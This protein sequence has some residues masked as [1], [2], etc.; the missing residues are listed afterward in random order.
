MTIAAN[1]NIDRIRERAE[2]VAQRVAA[3]QGGVPLPQEAPPEE[4]T[5]GQNFRRSFK[6]S[7]NDIR[8]AFNE[9]TG[10][11]EEAKKVRRDF[12]LRNPTSDSFATTLGGTL[13]SLT[14]IAGALAL[15][16]LTG[17][18]SLPVA[19][20]AA[21]GVFAMQAATAAG[22]ALHELNTFEEETGEK[23][24]PL[25]KTAVAAGNAAIVYVASRIGFEK[26]RGIGIRSAESLGQAVVARGQGQITRRQL[27]TT[28]AK[29]VPGFAAAG[30]TV[31]ALEEAAEEIGSNALDAAFGTGRRTLFQNVR[32]AALAGA[33]GGSLLG[34]LATG[35]QIPGAV[36]QARFESTRQRAAQA[37]E[38]AGQAGESLLTFLRGETDPRRFQGADVTV[39]EPEL[40]PAPDPRF[41]QSR[42][43]RLFDSLA[44]QPRFAQEPGVP[45]LGEEAPPPAERFGPQDIGAER[46]LERGL[47]RALANE[48]MRELARTGRP[49]TS[50]P[51]LEPQTPRQ[52][53][54]ATETPQTPATAPQQPTR[55][56]DLFTGDVKADADTAE[57]LSAILRNP[58]LPD[59]TV[60]DPETLS[61]IGNTLDQLLEQRPDL[62]R[63]LVSRAGNVVE[64]REAEVELAAQRT[65]LDENIVRRGL[66]DP[67]SDAALE[68]A[69]AEALASIERGP[70]ATREQ[71]TPPSTAIRGKRA[72]REQ[73]LPPKLPR[74]ISLAQVNRELDAEMPPLDQGINPI[75]TA[76]SILQAN[77]GR[78]AQGNVNVPDVLTVAPDDLD[79]FT[80]VERANISKAGLAVSEDGAAEVRAVVGSALMDRVI[81]FAKRGF[82]MSNVRGEVSPAL[83]NE[84]V[85]QV[86]DHP[87]RFSPRTRLNA[88]IFRQMQ[89]VTRSITG[90]VTLIDPRTLPIGT[91]IEVLGHE[92]EVVADPETDGRTTML[93][94]D[95]D[96]PLFLNDVTAVPINRIDLPGPGGE[97][98][99]G[100]PS[101][102]LTGNQGDLFTPP[103]QAPIAAETQRRLDAGFPGRT[104]PQA[105]GQ[106]FLGSGF[107]A[108][109]QY[110]ERFGRFIK[111]TQARA[112]PQAQARIDSVA[113]QGI[114]AENVS[115]TTDTKQHVITDQATRSAIKG[116]ARVAARSIATTVRG[117]FQILAE[118]SARLLNSYAELS[119]RAGAKE[120]SQTLRRLARRAKEIQ[121]RMAESLDNVQRLG[122]PKGPLANIRAQR[123]GGWL[124]SDP[125]GPQ[126]TQGGIDFAETAWRLASEGVIP[127]GDIPADQKPAIDAIREFNKVSGVE[128]KKAKPGFE[129]AGKAPRVHTPGWWRTLRH[130]DSPMFDRV[131]KATAH[132]NPNFRHASEN[133]AIR[134]RFPDAPIDAE[135]SVR[136]FFLEKSLEMDTDPRGR[137]TSQ[138]PDPR[139]IG[140]DFVRAFDRFPAYV[141]DPTGRMIALLEENVPVWAQRTSD[142]VSAR[143]A[144]LTEVGDGP[145]ALRNLRERAWRETGS[146]Q[147]VDEAVLAMNGIPFRS[148][149]DNFAP[150]TYASNLLDGLNEA[151]NLTASFALTAAV[152]PNTAEVF[153]GNIASRFGYGVSFRALAKTYDSDFMETLERQGAH[154]RVFWEGLL[155][156]NR[157]IASRLA[158]FRSGLRRITF[159]EM[160][161][162]TQE[163]QGAAAMTLVIDDVRSGRARRGLIDDLAKFAK[164]EG[165]TDGQIQTIVNPDDSPA[166]QGLRND[167]I[168]QAA[169]RFTGGNKKRIE[170]SPFQNNP[171][172]NALFKFTSYPITK[173]RDMVDITRPVMDSIAKGDF[174]TPLRNGDGRRMARWYFGTAAQGMGAYA[175]LALATGGLEGFRLALTEAEDEPF[176]FALESF[177]YSAFAGPF[178][179]IMRVMSGDDNL[180][181]AAVRS[182]FPG[183][184][185]MEL[186]QAFKSEGPYRD[187]SPSERAA[188]FFTRR[189]PA[190][191]SLRQAMATLGL[192]DFS[193]GLESA[194]G[195]YYRWKRDQPGGADRFVAGPTDEETATFRRHMRRAMES[196]KRG[197]DPAEDLERAAGTGKDVRRSLL[198]RRLLSPLDAREIESLTQRIGP[199]AMAR[200]RAYDT[201]LEGWANGIGG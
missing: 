22:L 201:V 24:D 133:P 80:A 128:F 197:R 47:G 196:I 29:A 62:E 74:G 59:G 86:M 166:A 101:Q 72:R 115:T 1:P 93:E 130:P 21:K 186:E 111:G 149:A 91:K 105:S 51:G 119:E 65:G 122:A 145:D 155:D 53:A 64:A 32:Q 94:N 88:I 44:E 100:Q 194:I 127:E 118:R 169:Q 2:A 103:G 84:F 66:A 63:E 109:Q 99:F 124:M 146:R 153:S 4:P 8:V 96:I 95:I 58:T 167:L 18:A 185:F 125:F 61:T 135:Q 175:L 6:G 92:Y 75:N 177:A 13:G 191:R 131:V 31:E 55:I 181:T 161:N 25:R 83:R 174:T 39:D 189:T 50:V 79:G 160:L 73:D 42:Q 176:E 69:D 190:V 7:F 173:M 188:T 187:Q 106:M 138:A 43:G 26:L 129:L 45:V 56:A 141:R 108:M 165:F 113:S 150:G 132:L 3:R 87:D 48:A 139:Q 38:G 158:A 49:R 33:I 116:P 151:V 137:T 11:H 19:G 40:G 76:E 77:R 117:P 10:D 34:P 180:P 20:V 112:M 15:A 98:L 35:V 157:P 30:A 200:L 148:F 97:G 12:Q 142:M 172:F 14:P 28:F 156:P 123:R 110:L 68:L 60:V 71:A 78:F 107:G 171:T 9:L 82:T 147:W 89:E 126:S 183:A 104:T 70:A 67:E 46:G 184:I 114:D 159:N 36:G 121:G 199:D 179:Q 164:D 195:G 41:P 17:G 81:A 136:E 154:D 57:R 52:A 192:S 16:P 178:G 23:I 102:P 170:Q 85:R 163:R 152:L 134:R 27:A 144:F 193:P 168:R 5:F 140:L 182:T 198:A 143:A 37:A 90:D 162:E 120:V 54:P